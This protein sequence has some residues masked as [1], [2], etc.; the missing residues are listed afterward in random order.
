MKEKL[1]NIWKKDPNNT[2]KKDTYKN[3]L[4][5]LKQ[6][7]NE[8]KNGYDKKQIEM[9]QNNQK[10]LW[11]IIKKKLG[12]ENNTN[13][14]TNYLKNNN[15]KITDSNQIADKMNEYFVI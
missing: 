15:I 3:Y 9:N 8:A 5:I 2:T 11:K 12:K 1:Y 10:N 7:I 6:T 13:D 4:K 14:N